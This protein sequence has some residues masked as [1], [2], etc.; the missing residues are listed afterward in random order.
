MVVTEKTEPGSSPRQTR[1]GHGQWVHT[2]G[3]DIPAGHEKTPPTRVVHRR[4]HVSVLGG[5][6]NS[7]RLSITWSSFGPWSWDYRPP[8]MPCQ[9]QLAILCYD[10]RESLARAGSCVHQQACLKGRPKTPELSWICHRC[11]VQGCVL[12][13]AQEITQLLQLRA[14]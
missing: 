7:T 8:E 10:G 14:P 11:P 2:A 4:N 5:A 13:L 12:Q 1:I 3:W 6:Q 9:Q